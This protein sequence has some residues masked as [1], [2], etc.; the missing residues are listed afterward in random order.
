MPNDV[1]H[2]RLAVMTS[3]SIHPTPAALCCSGEI[4]NCLQDSQFAVCKFDTSAK[5][6]YTQRFAVVGAGSTGMY[7]CRRLLR[8]LSQNKLLLRVSV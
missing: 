5:R 2:I 4:D 8:S 6:I 1:T 3:L 7:R